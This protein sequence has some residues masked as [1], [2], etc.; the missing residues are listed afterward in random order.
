MDPAGCRG[1]EQ[2]EVVRLRPV[3]CER[4][5]LAHSC[6]S[7]TSGPAIINRAADDSEQALQNHGKVKTRA[8]AA[9]STTGQGAQH[10]LNDDTPPQQGVAKHAGVGCHMEHKQVR[11]NKS[12]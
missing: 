12:Y 1:E 2:E 7:V 6:Q 8:L 3:R 10:S 9:A 11:Q 4:V 5:H